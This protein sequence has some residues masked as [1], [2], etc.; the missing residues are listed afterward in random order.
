MDRLLSDVEVVSERGRLN[1]AEVTSVEHDSRLVGRGALFCCV[2]GAVTDGHLFAGEAVARGAVGLLVERPQDLDVAQAVVPEGAVRR[3]MAKAAA[4]FYGHPARSL[5][6]VGVTGTNGKTT[7]THLLASIFEAHG[8]P[9]TVIGTLGGARTTPEAP[10]LQRLL[11]QARDSGRRCACV[12]VSS[13]ALTQDRVEGMRFDAAVFTNLGHDHL[14]HHGTMQRY[15]EAKASLFVP[16][17]AAI[18]I[19]RGDDP[20]GR[21][22]VADSPIE[23]VAYSLSDAQDVSMDASRTVFTWRGRRVVLGLAGLFQVPNALAA[24]TAAAA[25]GV[26]EQTVVEGLAGAQPVP[27]RFELVDTGLRFTTVVDYAHTPEGLQVALES[28]RRLAGDHRV[29]VVFGAG[30]ER[31]REKRPAM[32]AAAVG[33][34]DLVVLTS[35]NPRGEDPMAI[36]HAVLGGVGEGAHVLVEPDRGRAIE[37]VFERAGD[38][39]VV[40]L[41]GKGHETDMELAGARVDF[42]DRAAALAAAGRV[43]ARASG[44]GGAR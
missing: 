33:G 14:D 22:L 24:A 23:I 32:G 11:A 9:T 43:Q 28:A 16:E 41:A 35:D 3:S 39:D 20:W 15:F 10:L 26:P 17:R 44:T 7:V 34:A 31:D 27:G 40:L 4:T 30:G 38:G 19:V 25:L 12:E 29:L 5:L 21:R 42:D 2:S 1:A 8:A 13:H 6:T 36:I 18:G 37:A